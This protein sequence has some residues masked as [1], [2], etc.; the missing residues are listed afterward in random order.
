M[1]PL[2]ESLSPA[3]ILSRQDLTSPSRQDKNAGNSGDLVKHTVYLAL[4]NH[5][6]R[7]GRKAHIVEAH[8]GKG[9]YVSSNPHLRR[10]LQAARYSTSALGRAQSGSFAP[11]PAGLGVVAD[12]GDE[13]IAYAGSFALHAIA[14]ANP[15]ERSAAIGVQAPRR[16][17]ARVGA[18]CVVPLLTEDVMPKDLARLT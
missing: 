17:G 11:P 12:W 10:V 1:P 14:V 3:Q 4:L 8:G 18:S 15:R 16:P 7:S 6:T 5:L 13:E 9:M 2:L